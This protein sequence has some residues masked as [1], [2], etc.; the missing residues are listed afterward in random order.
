MTVETG[1]PLDIEAPRSRRTREPRG[2]HGRNNFELHAWLFMRISGIVLIVL[3]LGH[4]L[5][6]NVLDGG[7]QR[8]NF[9]FVAGRW[10]SPFWRLWDLLMLWLAELHGTNGLRTVINDYA[11]RPQTRFWLKTLLYCSAVLVVSLGT[12]VIFTFDPT[13]SN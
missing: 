9:G 2:R 4:L 7:V 8:I 13:I 10:S 11:E 6:M 12:L 3:V 5:I 1:P